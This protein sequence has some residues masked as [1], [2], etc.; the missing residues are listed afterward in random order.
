METAYKPSAFSTKN[1]FRRDYEHWQG[2]PKI[3]I[4]ILRLM[5]FLMIVFLGKDSWTHILSFK[6][7]W[8]PAN[9]VAWCIWVPRLKG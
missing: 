7:V 2:V 4:Y 3:N 8:N 1:I 6:G 9:A 5:F